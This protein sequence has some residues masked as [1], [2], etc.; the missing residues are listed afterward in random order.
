MSN[1]RLE[2]LK[3]LIAK[4]QADREAHVEAIARIDEAFGTLGIQP[5]AKKGRRPRRPSTKA[6]TR[7]R[8][9][10]KFK[11][12]GNESILTFVRAAGP[13]GVS[14]AQLVQHWKAE[15]RGVG[16]YNLLGKLIKD[17][18][19]KRRKLKGQKGSLYVAG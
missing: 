8:P 2:E 3:S 9:R 16:C 15:G 13:K 19:I 4:L 7:R 17:K 12:T 1:T 5:P 6:S 11:T 18:R 10:R 14:G